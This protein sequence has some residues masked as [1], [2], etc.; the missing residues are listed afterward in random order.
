MKSRQTQLPFVQ[1]YGELRW[2]TSE[3]GKP[4]MEVA[5]EVGEGGGASITLPPD[6]GGRGGPRRFRHRGVVGWYQGAREVGRTTMRGFGVHHVLIIPMITRN[7][8][9]HVLALA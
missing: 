5:D 3:R 8:T 1:G 7:S 9:A 4:F 6:S 2:R